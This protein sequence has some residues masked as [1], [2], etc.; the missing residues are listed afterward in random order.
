MSSRDSSPRLAQ[1][2]HADVGG[3]Q[4][5]AFTIVLARVL[6]L[7]GHSLEGSRL[8]GGVAPA[9]QDVVCEP[10]VEGK[11]RAQGAPA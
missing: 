6:D 5:S 9:P 10:S 11:R 4:D 1:R 8:A 2:L 3:V 7:D